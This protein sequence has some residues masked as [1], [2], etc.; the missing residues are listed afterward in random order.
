MST[1]DA[2]A[3]IQPLHDN[4]HELSG[5]LEGELSKLQLSESWSTSGGRNYK[6]LTT[7]AN[8][9]QFKHADRSEGIKAQENVAL[10]ARMIYGE[11][12]TQQL[13]GD[14]MYQGNRIRHGLAGSLA[15]AIQMLKRAHTWRNPYVL[16]GEGLVAEYVER[17]ASTSRFNPKQQIEAE[18][19]RLIYAAVHRINEIFYVHEEHEN[20]SV[21]TYRGTEYVDMHASVV[22]YFKLDE[23][24][25]PW[26]DE[27]PSEETQTQIPQVNLSPAAEDV[28][29]ARGIGDAGEDE[30]DQTSGAFVWNELDETG[31]NRRETNAW[32][33][34]SDVEGWW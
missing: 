10:L 15:W 1:E 8:M 33:G 30:E 4:V 32:D 28:L 27:R 21:F 3:W 5:R 14:E 34:G 24:D 25:V 6:P 17:F 22:P 12:I 19:D 23:T 20:G 16:F 18:L 2:K 7:F 26:R 9:L 13:H 11:W 31:A 29:R